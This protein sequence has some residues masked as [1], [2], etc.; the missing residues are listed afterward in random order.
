MTT[1]P[2]RKMKVEQHLADPALKQRYVTTMFDLVA[3]SYD[4]FTRWFSYGMDRDWKAALVSRACREMNNGSLAIDLA[5]GTGDIA[6]AVAAGSRAQVIGV[7]PSARMLA[8]AR[9]RGGRVEYLKGDMLA[10]PVST[11]EASV[12]TAAYGFRNAP[13]HRAALREVSRALQ[14]G[15]VLLVLDFYQP[16]AVWWRTLFLMYLSAAG[17]LYGWAWHGDPAAYSYIARS[18]SHYVTAS[19]FGRDLTAAGFSIER[20]QRH[21]GGGICFH[22]AR[23]R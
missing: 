18:I 17:A 16:E 8:I 23:K 2:L 21:L 20:V 1:S 5:C 12:I 9:E 14:P 15:G 19:E 6:L 3:P 13:D 4:R 7:D 10:L 22:V 11:G